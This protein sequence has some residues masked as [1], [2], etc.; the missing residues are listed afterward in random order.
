MRADQSLY[1]HPQR[2]N[3]VGPSAMAVGWN[4]YPDVVLE[5]DRTTDVRRNKLKVYAA[6]GFPEVWVEVP[7]DSSR[8]RKLW[9]RRS[10][11]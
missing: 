8:P 9:A 10:T 3:I 5:V 6:W 1:L 11:C 7:E 4:H 2:A